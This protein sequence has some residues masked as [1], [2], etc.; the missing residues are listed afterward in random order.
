MDAIECLMTR[1]S[2]RRY[3]KE[4]VKEDDLLSMLKCALLAPSGSNKQVWELF[5]I[6]D[7]ER[8]AKLSE[9]CTYGRFIRDAPL[10]IVVAGD[11]AKSGHILEDCSAASENILLAA[12]ALGYG[13]CWIAGWGKPYEDGVLDIIGAEKVGKVRLVSLIP[14]GVPDGRDDPKEKRSSEDAVHFV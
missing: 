8:L 12:H 9:V 11:E 1:R 2:V 4:D 10:C 3:K 6:Q 13:G 7:K 14:I 5:V